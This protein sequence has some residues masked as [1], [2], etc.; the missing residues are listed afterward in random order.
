MDDEI[1]D[2]YQSGDERDR[3]F[4]HGRPRLE[5]VRTIE[6]LNRFLPTAPADVLDVGGGA[7]AYA[8]PLAQRG[9]RVRLLDPVALH[10]EQAEAASAA[11]PETPF[12]A[13]LGDARHLE[14]PDR[15]YD[16]VLLMGPLYHLVE[17]DERVLA[18]REGRR[19]L[20][21]G[22]VVF[23]VGISRFR[24]LLA[25]LSE[26]ILADPDFSR[27][28]TRDLAEGQHRNP[29]RATHPERWTTAFFHHPNELAAELVDAGFRLE[30]LLGIEGPGW[31]Y[32]DRW[33]DPDYR[34]GILR[35]AR[36]VEAE[37]TL[38]GMSTHVAAIGRR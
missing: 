26:G 16:A 22:G 4:R 5:Y 13:A 36:A 23:A 10:V 18:L 1:R 28:V 21:N 6:L 9:Y 37:P 3:L 14:V 29:M 12:A 11:Q 19:V 24:S 38:L 34:V 32:E 25:G 30:A 27:I 35:A 8:A 17:R 20:R 7:G 2:T 31:L 33:A 15:S